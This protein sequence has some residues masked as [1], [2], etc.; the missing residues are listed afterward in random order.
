MIYLLHQLLEASAPKYPDHKAVIFRGKS[1]SYRDLNIQANKLANLLLAHGIGRGERVAL[2]LNKSIEAIVA[3]FGILKSGAAYV[4]LDINAPVMRL[5]YILNNCAVKGLISTKEKVRKISDYLG[6]DSPLGV[7]VSMEGNFEANFEKSIKILNPTDIIDNSS[8][9]N[10]DVGGT[11]GDLAYILYTSGST[12][13]PKGVMIS[14]LNALNFVNW[15]HDTFRV[16]SQDILS[17]HAPFHFDL[18]IHDIYVAFKAGATLCPVPEEYSYFPYRLAEWIDEHKISVWYSV[19]S[20]LS[21]MV[22]SGEIQRFRFENLRTILFAGEVFPVKYL[23][24]LMK[25]IPH[26]EYYNL[27]GPT[28]T[29]VI[30]YYR[31]QTIPEDQI[32]P[33]PIGIVCENMEI[34]LIDDNGH[35]ITAPGIQGEIYG[36]GGNI[37]QG[38]WGDPAK[39]SKGF[40]KNFLQPHYDEIIYKTGD[41]AM[42]DNSSNFIFFGRK[43]HM[44]KSRGYRIELGE[45]ETI[46]YQHPDIKE[47]AV[48]A[49]PDEKI[50]NRLKAFVVIKDG[51]KTDSQ[52]IQKHL[53]RSL[54]KYMVPEQIEFSKNLPKNPHGKIDRTLLAQNKR[55]GE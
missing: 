18:S 29:N 11:W 3:L 46:L 28:E 27:F 14:H 13:N 21:M 16:I 4:P 49:V 17:N 38:Y 33:I 20:I 19:P 31:V 55:S 15:S 32:K 25:L 10:P 43:D 48:I 24:E 40:I 39:T 41:L 2:Y 12:G 7:I 42:L 5:N 36:R 1:I 50:T 44:V 37:A 26:P 23:R 9:E 53:A 52:D 45:I 8:E 30:T 22:M 34:L 54:P 6:N 51:K 47:A 35:R